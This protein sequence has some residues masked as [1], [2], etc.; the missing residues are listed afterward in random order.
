MP[1]VFPVLSSRGHGLGHIVQTVDGLLVASRYQVAVDVDGYLDRVVPHLFLHV[2]ER[3]ALLEEQ[4]CKTT[5][6][7]WQDDL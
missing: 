3:F 2:G 7:G 5:V 4:G 6:N 1:C